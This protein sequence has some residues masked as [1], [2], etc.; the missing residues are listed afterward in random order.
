MDGYFQLFLLQRKPGRWRENVYEEGTRSEPTFC[1]VKSLF[2]LWN[3]G[4]RSLQANQSHFPSVK[5]KRE[6]WHSFWHLN[7]YV[8]NSSL[9]RIECIY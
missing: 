6:D 9:L 3:R 1:E 8:Q 5:T 7:L 4:I 2:G